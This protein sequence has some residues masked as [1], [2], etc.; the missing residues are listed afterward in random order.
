MS[1]RI[2]TISRPISRLALIS[3]T[4]RRLRAVPDDYCGIHHKI[5]RRHDCRSAPP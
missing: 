2:G 4:E 5:G 3:I 1:V